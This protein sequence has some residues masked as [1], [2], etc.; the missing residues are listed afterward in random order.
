MTDVQKKLIEELTKNAKTRGS[1]TSTRKF[2]VR[3]DGDKTQK[4][5][6]QAVTILATI[7]AL[8][9]K[10]TEQEIVEAVEKSDL[11]TKQEKSRIW[12]YYR[13][14]LVEA[15]WLIEVK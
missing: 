15:K 10:I 4:L 8:D 13:K 2:E 5:S 14:S 7:Y 9:K 3:T 6:P 12:M 1:K 11:K